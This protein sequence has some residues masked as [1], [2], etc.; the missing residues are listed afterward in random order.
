MVSEIFALAILPQSYH[1]LTAV[2]PKFARKPLPLGMGMNGV[3]LVQ[4]D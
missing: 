4:C 3:I 1:G 2:L